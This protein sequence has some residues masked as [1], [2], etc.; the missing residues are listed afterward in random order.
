MMETYVPSP[1]KILLEIPMM[2][3]KAH[4]QI[5]SK[6]A[7]YFRYFVPCVVIHLVTFDQREN[8]TKD[9][10]LVMTNSSIIAYRRISSPLR[11]LEFSR[12][13]G[14]RVPLEGFFQ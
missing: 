11:W 10:Y 5:Y 2:G 6:T 8:H 7:L 9:L 12:H 3:H 1:P 14:D 13:L 4:S